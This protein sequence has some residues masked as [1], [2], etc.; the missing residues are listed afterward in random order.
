MAEYDE[1]LAS[2]LWEVSARVSALGEAAL[3]THSVSRATLGMLNVI[4]RHP[5]ISAAEI[6]RRLP[7]TQQSVSQLV[8][9]LVRV[10]LVDRRVG[11]GRGFGLHLTAHGAKTR[12]AGDAADVTYERGLED[13][14]GT[15]RYEELRSMLRDAN[16][17]VVAQGLDT[18]PAY[19]TYPLA[20]PPAVAPPA[21]RRRKSP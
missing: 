9:R 14:F 15:K 5:G 2:L 17:V 3:Q 18:P 20:A 6:A 10:G 1:R 12:S 16:A 4:H 21:R 19:P 7:V 13:I 8:T 11:P